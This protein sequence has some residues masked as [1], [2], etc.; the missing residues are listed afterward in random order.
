MPVIPGAQFRG[1]GFTSPNV[2]RV[3]RD[4]TGAGLALIGRSA[5][6]AADRLAQIDEQDNR[7][8]V[9]KWSSATRLKHLKAL[10][11]AENSGKPLDGLTGQMEAAINADLQ[12]ALKDRPGAR[13]FL[14]L[15]GADIAGDLSLNAGR[16]ES[17]DRLTRRIASLGEVMRNSANAAATDPTLFPKLWAEGNAAIE[18]A[19]LP[20]E[21]K[22]K[23]RAD[24]R[25]V[26]AS[27]VSGMIERNP[28]AATAQLEGGAW[29]KYLDPGARV[30][31][32]NGAQAA[33]RSREAEAR[34]RAAESRAAAAEAANSYLD[35]ANDYFAWRAAGNAPDPVKE[36]KYSPE[37]IAGLPIKGADKLARKAADAYARGELMFALRN[38]DT[39]EERAAIVAE[40]DRQASNPENFAFNSDTQKLVRTTAAE[41]EAEL[42]K[43]PGTVAARSQRVQDAIK[44]GDTPGIVKAMYGEQDRL[45]VPSYAQVALP[46]EVAASLTAQIAEMAP[47]KQVEAVQGLAAEYGSYWPDVFR[48]IGNKLPA[49][50]AT[51][52]VMPYGEAAARLAA[53][54][55]LPVSD[56]NAGVE[57]PANV[58]KAITDNETMAALRASLAH[59][60][61]GAA[62][63]AQ[64]EKGV[65]ALAFDYVRSGLGEEE[66]VAKAAEAVNAGHAIIETNDGAARIPSGEKP[67]MVQAGMESIFDNFDPAQFD[68][69]AS[70]TGTVLGLE[71]ADI[72]RAQLSRNGTWVNDSD[73]LGL[74][75]YD[76]VNFVTKDGNPVLFTWEALRR[77]GVE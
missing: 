29:D 53:V 15:A 4:Q 11:D 72:R 22:E 34:A 38:A 28:Y 65:Q 37:Q 25:D 23:A 50:L 12:Q 31:L 68:G 54:S 60:A 42:T 47:D 67:D 21:F 20:V 64:I 14:E 17:K 51:V 48:Q 36:A 18:S 3:E 44:A 66:A 63:Y 26:A 75:L 8:F 32:Y 16:V 40:A 2:P 73:G 10:Q 76:G 33:V 27:A 57:K 6:E 30:S 5:R 55:K 61:N 35:D 62:T 39:P 52:A 46:E 58:T 9:A 45:G 74:Y 69:V 43:T 71:A 70:D 41:F 24:L 13:D 49:E 59:E 1:P 7:L 77:A 19:A 56:R